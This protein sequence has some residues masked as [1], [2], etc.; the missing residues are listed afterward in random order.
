MSARLDHVALAV[1]DERV[2]VGVVGRVLG[3]KR[4]VRSPTM[5]GVRPMSVC[6]FLFDVNGT[7]S[8]CGKLELITTPFE[9]Q[10]G[11]KPDT[12]SFMAKFLQSKGE[13]V[14]HITFIV[15]RE[16]EDLQRTRKVAER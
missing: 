7:G 1:R 5:S 8:G 4:L 10:W 3:G 12:S 9:S 11:G 14:H 6:S 2:A 13:V 16:L 15:G